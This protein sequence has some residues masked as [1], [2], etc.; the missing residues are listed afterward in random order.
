MEELK[1]KLL[2]PGGPYEVS[3]DRWFCG[4][5]EIEGYCFNGSKCPKILRSLYDRAFG[6]YSEN[7]FVV[8]Q[9]ERYTYKKMWNLAS[10]LASYFIHERNIKLGDRIAIC[11]RNYP[12]WL[13]VFLA[14]TAIGAVAVPLNSLWKTREL[15]YVL[16][17]SKPKILVCDQKRFEYTR[18]TVFELDVNVIRV[19]M[20]KHAVSGGDS[21]R[22]I[23][24]RYQGVR[25]P[26]VANMR[27]DDIACIMYTSGTT[28]FPKGVVLTHRG[29]C[30]QLSMSLAVDAIRELAGATETNKANQPCMICPVPLFHVTASHHIFLSTLSKGGKLVLMYKWDAGV[31]LRLIQDERPTSWTGVPTMVQDLME[32]PDFDRYDTSSLKS[33]GGGGGPTPASQVAKTAKRFRGGAPGQ[34]YGLTETN[35]GVCF[36]SGED[37]LARPTSCGKPYPIVDV[38]VVALD[39][40]DEKKPR[41][42][43]GPNMEGELIVSCH[44]PLLEQTGENCLRDRRSGRT[45]ARLVSNGRHRTRRQGLLRVHHGSRQRYN[46]SRRGKYFVRSGRDCVLRERSGIGVRRSRHQG[47]ALG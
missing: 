26:V 2:G 18:K 24:T 31:A 6:T 13:C 5:R 17:D 47:R 28:G 23:V 11:M 27:R 44:E 3:L 43:L 40:G 8:Y 7:T 21:F 36:N 29:V 4:H 45:R 16:R 41:R 20:D 9:N 1:T 10:S 37:Y 25:M 39:A 15:D 30:G 32:H 19:R 22:E 42:A 12:E 35:G 38:C 34:G 33:I 14:A 46:H